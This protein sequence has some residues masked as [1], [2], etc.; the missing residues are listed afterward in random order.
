MYVLSL[1]PNYLI[2]LREND[3]PLQDARRGRPNLSWSGFARPFCF[4][5]V[6]Y[7]YIW[8]YNFLHILLSTLILLITTTYCPFYKFLTLNC[9]AWYM[10]DFINGGIEKTEEKGHAHI[11]NRLVAGWLVWNDKARWSLWKRKRLKRREL[12][13]VYFHKGQ[14]FE[15]E[16]DKRREWIPIST[17]MGSCSPYLDRSFLWLIL[18]FAGQSFEPS[19]AKTDGP[20]AH[21]RTLGISTFYF[22]CSGAMV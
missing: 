5:N 22:Y 10:I 1:S 3:F 9:Y 17:R 2:L 16:K 7:I 8:Y 18:R 4:P 19:I 14:V 6:C 15:R 12:R 11:Y 21:Y 20:N 13:D